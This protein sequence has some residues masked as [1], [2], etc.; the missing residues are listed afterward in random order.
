MQCKICGLNVS[1]GKELRYQ[2]HMH[3]LIQQN[4]EQAENTLRLIAMAR[5]LDQKLKRRDN[6]ALSAANAQILLLQDQLREAR[7]AGQ[8]VSQFVGGG[9]RRI[10]SAQ[11]TA[12]QQNIPRPMERGQDLRPPSPKPAPVAAPVPAEPEK[13]LN[14]FELLELE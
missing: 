5:D 10:S 11:R 6:E 14:R 13:K 3:C 2:Y 1:E 8:L 9:N 7:E 4:K 12:A